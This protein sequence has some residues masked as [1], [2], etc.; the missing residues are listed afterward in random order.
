MKKEASLAPQRHANETMIAMI[1]KQQQAM[2]SIDSRVNALHDRAATVLNR[3][4]YN[5]FRPGA[6]HFLDT[7]EFDGLPRSFSPRVPFSI[8]NVTFQLRYLLPRP[9]GCDI[10]RPVDLVTA[11]PLAILDALQTILDQTHNDLE[12]LA[13]EE[14][15]MGAKLVRFEQLS[16]QVIDAADV[17]QQYVGLRGYVTWTYEHYLSASRSYDDY[18]RTK[19]QHPGASYVKT[20][21]SFELHTAANPVRW[22]T[23]RAPLVPARLQA[24]D[25]VRPPHRDP[26]DV[27]F[28]RQALEVSPAYD[29]TSTASAA[30]PQLALV[31]TTPR[32]PLPSTRQGYDRSEL[33]VGKENLTTTM[34]QDWW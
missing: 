21:D 9:P 20:F 25:Y 1:E 3:L 19:E 15:E 12:T 14:S 8:K 29:G 7:D 33:S 28:Q 32:P 23:I 5:V 30:S 31:P 24:P 13:R 17:G 16:K 4:W 11:E 18:R 6:R 26:T 34:A 22:P 10:P 2:V 27:R